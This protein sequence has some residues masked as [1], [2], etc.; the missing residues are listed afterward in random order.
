MIDSW[1]TDY[2]LH[3][4]FYNESKMETILMITGILLLGF[5]INV[6]LKQ[7]Y[8][9]IFVIEHKPVLWILIMGIVSALVWGISAIFSWNVNIPAWSTTIAFFMNLP[10][11][12]KNREEK[13]N[14]NQMV[15]EFYSGM[16]IKHGRLLYRLGLIS[17]VLSGIASW[18]LFYGEICHECL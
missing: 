3:I 12:H 7:T 10:P 18:I 9:F 4:D 6:L 1:S 13:E 14:V 17:F 11:E 5:V 16:G 2:S 8:N 15:D